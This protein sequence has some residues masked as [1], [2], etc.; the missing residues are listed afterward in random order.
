MALGEQ[1]VLKRLCRDK[2][3]LSAEMRRRVGIVGF[4]HL[5]QFLAAEV[6]RRP[7]SLELAFVWSRGR[8]QG[9][10]KGLVLDD[11]AYA[12]SRR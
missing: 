1:G 8:V 6:Q 12:A 3:S 7:E 10:D 4:G 9:L 5:G 11:L 2:R